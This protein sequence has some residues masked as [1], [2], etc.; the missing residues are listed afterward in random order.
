[1]LPLLQ[2]FGE[3]AIR[4]ELPEVLPLR[5]ETYTMFLVAILS[6]SFLLIS[7]SRSSNSKA[8]QS[9]AEVFFR[10][11]SSVEVYLKAN[12]KIGS[13]SSITLIIKYK[14]IVVKFSFSFTRSS[15]TLIKFL[16]TISVHD[17]LLLRQ[18]SRLLNISVLRFCMASLISMF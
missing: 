13:W 17:E 1:M 2:V 7:F 15:P 4:G 16:F 12:M 9:V 5:E 8:L 3:T 14:S 18:A 11:S 10:D 6:F